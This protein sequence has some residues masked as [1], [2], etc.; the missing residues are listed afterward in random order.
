MSLGV[1]PSDS[2]TAQTCSS[3][4]CGSDGLGLLHGVSFGALRLFIVADGLVVLEQHA[5]ERLGLLLVEACP[6]ADLRE[7]SAVAHR[8]G[9]ESTQSIRRSSQDQK[10]KKTCL[11]FALF[12]FSIPKSKK[13]QDFDLFLVFL[14]LQ[15]WVAYA[16]V[17]AY[18][19]Y[20]LIF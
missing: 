18:P 6:L 13:V 4:V 15:P 19:L 20:Y 16:I 1:A 7:Q 11:V 5:L 9:R 14:V 10:S 17:P 12:T 2:A 8:P 3:T